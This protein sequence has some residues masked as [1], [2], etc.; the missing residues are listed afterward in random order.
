MNDPYSVLGLQRGASEEEVKKAYKSLAKR[1]HPDVTGNDPAAA[2]KMQEI[3]AAYDM[4]MN[5]KEQASG[6]YGYSSYQDQGQ[7]D[8]EPIEMQAAANYINARRFREALNALGSVPP[9]SRNGRWYYLSSIARYYTGDSM[10]ARQDIDAALSKEPG[11]IAYINL[12]NQMD[13]SRNMYQ[14]YTGSY[15]RSSGGLGTFC[16]TMIL[17]RL[18]CWC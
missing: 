12:R 16:L 10:G 14:E 15:R 7:R 6:G 3:N 11:N 18:C 13:G 9:S 2:K 8:E 4:I 1:Y 17:C 5:R